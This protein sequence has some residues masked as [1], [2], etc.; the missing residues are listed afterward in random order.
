MLLDQTDWGYLRKSVCSS[1][2]KNQNIGSLS[3]LCNLWAEFELLHNRCYLNIILGQ[4]ITCSLLFGCIWSRPDKVIR[5]TTSSI[6]AF[7]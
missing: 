5:D 3:V 6:P 7:M 4:F 2:K 1:T